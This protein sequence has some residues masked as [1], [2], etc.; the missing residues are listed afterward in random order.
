MAS[1]K[2]TDEAP[3]YLDRFG[4]RHELSAKDV[5]E[6]EQAEQQMLPA[7]PPAS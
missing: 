4:H 2:K 6:Q 1:R 5:Q 3:H 7:L